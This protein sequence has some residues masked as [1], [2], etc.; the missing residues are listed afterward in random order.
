M[1]AN[2]R[3]TIIDGYN[4]IHKLCKVKAGEPMDAMRKRLEAMLPRYR[5]KSRRHVTVVYDGG[6]G[7]RPH[8][9]RAGIDVTYSGTFKSADS[10]IIDHVRSLEPRP[11]MM[12]VVTSDREIQRHATAWGARCI[13]SEAFIEELAAMGLTADSQSGSSRKASGKSAGAAPLSDKEVDYWLQ[14]FERKK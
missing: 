6:S 13:D 10:W 9:S 2:Y 5:Q 8:S 7:P 1:F 14:L 4:L 11:G 3:E 12:L